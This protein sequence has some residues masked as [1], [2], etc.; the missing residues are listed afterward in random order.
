M[1]S[2]ILFTPYF[3]Q[4]YAT[5]LWRLRLAVVIDLGE[6]SGKWKVIVV[7]EGKQFVLLSM[8]IWHACSES[9]ACSSYSWPNRPLSDALINDVQEK[10]SRMPLIF[11]TKHTF[12]IALFFK[13][14]FFI[15]LKISLLTA[16]ASSIRASVIRSWRRCIRKKLHKCQITAFL[17]QDR[18]TWSDDASLGPGLVQ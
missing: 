17:Q 18:F 4:V 3:R 15:Y 13:G 16:C 2:R 14:F 6:I 7:V 5:F 1:A 12:R 9:T 11:K 8:R 10:I